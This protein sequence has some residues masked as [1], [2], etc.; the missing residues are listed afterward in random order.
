MRRPF[1]PFQSSSTNSTSM[2]LSQMISLKNVRKSRN[3]LALNFILQA[4]LFLVDMLHQYMLDR[5]LFMILF[6]KYKVPNST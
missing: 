6:V 1:S 5:V 3:S 4:W 2:S